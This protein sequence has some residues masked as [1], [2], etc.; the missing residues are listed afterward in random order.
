MTNKA[1]RGNKESK[2]APSMTLKAKRA[3]KKTKQDIKTA[4]QP[5]IV[6]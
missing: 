4:P 6:R 3:A 2:K 5:L 1:Q